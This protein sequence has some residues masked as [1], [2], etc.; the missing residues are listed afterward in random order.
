MHPMLSE[1]AADVFCLGLSGRTRTDVYFV[2]SGPAWVLVDTGWSSDGPRI[3]EAAASLFGRDARPVAILLSHV[4]PDHGGSARELARAW[5]CEVL[6]HPLEVPI[7]TGD[8][9]AM[10][11]YAGPLDRWVILPT[12]RAIGRQRREAI[13]AAGSLGDAVRGLDPAGAVPGLPDWEC[14]P[15]PGHTPGHVSF[16]RRSDRVLISGDA[17]VNLKVNSA[18]GLV[19][20]KAGLAGPPRYTSWRWSAAKESV[21]ALARL[22]PAVLAPGHGAPMVG[23]RTAGALRAFAERLSGRAVE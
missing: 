8:F 15:T 6:V 22:E 23:P 13:L 18:S 21:V 3:R 11:R 19:L 14:V 7:A 12:M 4:H 17:V 20:G 2:R 5:G 9:A 16:F 10:T 1:P